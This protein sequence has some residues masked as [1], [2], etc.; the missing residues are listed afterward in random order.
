MPI[1]HDLLNIEFGYWRTAIIA[2]GPQSVVPLLMGWIHDNHL[3]FVVDPNEDGPAFMIGE[4][5][6]G[7][8][9][10]GGFLEHLLKVDGPALAEFDH[11]DDVVNVHRSTNFTKACSFIPWKLSVLDS[12]SFLALIYKCV[13]G[14][15]YLRQV[16]QFLLLIQ[17]E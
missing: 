2:P 15:N 3:A 9:K 8:S 13:G 17:T 4:S 6:D 7:Q 16:R 12:R 14:L 11:F 1:I 5:H 10:A